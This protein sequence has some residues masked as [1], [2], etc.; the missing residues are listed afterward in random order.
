MDVEN[1]FDNE[2]G[3]TQG[4]YTDRVRDRRFRSTGHV[5]ICRS[6]TMSDL[7]LRVGGSDIVGRRFDHGSLRWGPISVGTYL[8]SD[9]NH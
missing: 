4:K 7:R 9:L 8:I 3:E 6:H 1:E 5:F 2:S